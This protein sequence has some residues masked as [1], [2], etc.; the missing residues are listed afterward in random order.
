MEKSYSSIKCKH[1]LH[2][3]EII[4]RRTSTNT[5]KA[6]AANNWNGKCTNYLRAYKFKTLLNSL[7]KIIL[8]HSVWPPIRKRWNSSSM[9]KVTNLCFSCVLLVVFS[10]QLWRK[11]H[12]QMLAVCLKGEVWLGIFNFFGFLV[13]DTIPPSGTHWIFIQLTYRCII[14]I[15]K[16]CTHCQLLYFSFEG[17][18]VEKGCN[19]RAKFSSSVWLFMFNKL[20]SFPNSHHLTLFF[21][22]RFI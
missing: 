5:F 3:L 20:Y 15:G 11:E 8:G 7:P 2:K 18:L 14:Y 6:Q 1:K 22:N 13:V 9:A 21:K 16:D 19:K 10:V 17:G 12:V 4:S